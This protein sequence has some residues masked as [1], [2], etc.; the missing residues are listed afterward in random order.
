LLPNPKNRLG[1]VTDGTGSLGA[2]IERAGCRDVLVPQKLAYDL[3]LAGV[4]VEKNLA[5]SMPESMR[6]YGETG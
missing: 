6:R 1:I 4:S 2:G 5:D 3:V